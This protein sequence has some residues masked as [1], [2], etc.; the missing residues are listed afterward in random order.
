MLVMC[1]G[2][3]VGLRSW[4]GIGVS[5]LVFLPSAIWRARLEEAALSSKFG[6][7]WIAY[8]KRTHFLLPFIY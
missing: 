5:I 8:Q 6:E 3:A 1:L 4:L 2:L 7:E